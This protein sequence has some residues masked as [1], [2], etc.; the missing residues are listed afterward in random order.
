[1]LHALDSLRFPAMLLVF[2][3][4][5][6]AASG[7]GVSPL[8]ED[9]GIRGALYE[10]T[11]AVTFFLVL[12]G[13][14]LA[15]VARAAFTERVA[16]DWFGFQVARIVRFYPLHAVFAV[17]FTVASLASIG[18][19]H[20]GSVAVIEHLLLVQ[21]WDPTR[22]MTLN[23]PAW[24]LSVELAAAVVL[25]L[26]M[27]AYAKA[28][29]GVRRWR[30]LVVI[31]VCWCWSVSLAFLAYGTFGVGLGGAIAL[32]HP[33]IRVPDVLA[34]A[35]LAFIT[36]GPAGDRPRVRAMS[37]RSWTILEVGALAAVIAMMSLRDVLP[38]PMRYGTAYLPV[39][40]LVTF[41]F[42]H[43]AG[44]VSRLLRHPA[45]LRLGA[46]S[47]A[48]YISHVLVL[49]LLEG[50]GTFERLGTALG[51]TLSLA[52]AIAVAE[53]L[54][55]HVQDPIQAWMRSVRRRRRAAEPR[56]GHHEDEDW[57]ERDAA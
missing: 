5:A 25:P 54:E 39:A 21:A 11:G 19:V 51:I 24:T 4:H 43:D 6:I 55:R 16:A 44:H 53:L 57:D 17:L 8:D 36:F 13:F 27:L 49:R 10:A 45:L 3:S 40:L 26:S 42:A 32:T 41:V 31:G 38:V 28:G 22:V 47:F 50:F 15:Y 1:V 12:S 52:I 48:F 2:A 34:G 9:Q 7:G 33:V 35:A 56:A 18:T 46:L 30:G 37:K 29:V 20:G 23:I 14:V